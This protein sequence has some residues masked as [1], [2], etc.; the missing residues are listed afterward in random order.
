MSA[1][2]EE[3]LSSYFLDTTLA[4]TTI[5]NPSQHGMVGFHLSA[6][7]SLVWSL[8]LPPKAWNPLRGC[9][10]PQDGYDFLF[11]D[12]LQLSPPNVRD[13]PAGVD[14]QQRGRADH[15]N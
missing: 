1:L 10:T 9:G 14:Q 12:R 13:F 4:L 2:R 7:I 8:P 11:V 3:A 6:Q 5:A 15:S